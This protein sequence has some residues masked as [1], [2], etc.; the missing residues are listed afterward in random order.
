MSR[1]R[2]EI[3][4]DENALID[5]LYKIKAS[6]RPIRAFVT[7]TA[8]IPFGDKPG[9]KGP[10]NG[11][12]LKLIPA[13]TTLRICMISRMGDFGLT[14]NLDAEYGYGVRLV[15]EDAAIDNIRLEP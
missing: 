6:H 3:S 8:E 5:A 9:G 13:G 10:W 11:D 1:P 12:Y 14:D 7:T 2:R 4:S 15:F